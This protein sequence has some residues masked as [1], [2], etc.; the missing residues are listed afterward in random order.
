MIIG[1]SRVDLFRFRIIFIVVLAQSTVYCF[2]KA[3]CKVHV[4]QPGMNLAL[5]ESVS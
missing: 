1:N 3:L 2:E 4:D 5:C